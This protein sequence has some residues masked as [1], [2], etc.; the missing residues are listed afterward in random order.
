MADP[1]QK[2][3]LTS[4]KLLV[5]L[6]KAYKNVMDSVSKDIRSYDLSPS[7]FG[8]LEVLHSKGRIPL[9]QIGEK[10]LIT[11][12]TMTYNIDKL[13][14]KGWIARI[15]SQEDRRVIFA[16]LT[17]QGQTFFGQIFPQHANRIHDLMGGLTQAQKEEAIELLKLLGKGANGV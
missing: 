6:S 4:L 15:P 16:E 2:E 3:E 12:G 10:I 8:I 9:Q 1:T 14:K 11:S 17:E 7:E 13:C 5:V